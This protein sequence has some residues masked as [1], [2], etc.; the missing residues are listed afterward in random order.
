MDGIRKE[1]ED[2]EIL[3]EKVETMLVK[4]K[5]QA[6]Q[7]L[8]LKREKDDLAAVKSAIESR[9]SDALMKADQV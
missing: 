6:K 2:T 4:S 8:L 7:H 1:F 3:K 5:E 9:L